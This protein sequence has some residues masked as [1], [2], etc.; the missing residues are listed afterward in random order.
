MIIQLDV[1]ERIVIN[2]K[3][4]YREHLFMNENNGMLTWKRVKLFK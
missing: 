1:F 3:G 2:L 4:I